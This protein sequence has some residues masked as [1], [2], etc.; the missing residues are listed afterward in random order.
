MTEYRKL[1]RGEAAGVDAVF[2]PLSR[3][4]FAASYPEGPHKLRHNLGA[5]P[6]LE[7]DALAE[8]AEALPSRSVAS[9]S[10]AAPTIGDTIRGIEAG[11]SWAVLRNIERH[12][13][14][15]ALLGEL[16][17]ELEAEIVAKTGRIVKTQGYVFLSGPH[18]VTPFHFRAAHNLLL[19]LAGNTAL[20]VFPAGD[21]L[22]APDRAHEAC[23]TGGARELAW[24]DE[25]ACFGITLR[26][27][28]GEAAFVPVKAPHHVRNC[29]RPS[30]ALSIAWHSEWSRAEADARACNGLLRRWGIEPRPPGRW[31]T[32]NTGKAI[33]WRILRGIPG[34]R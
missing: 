21:P 29:P 3:A 16:L 26:L 24:R 4:N 8:L 6:L 15:A 31:P 7:L 11:D 25:L 19:Q 30:I 9:N 33:A 23:R 17:D 27:A 22:F 10:T 5:H 20:T 28:A 14:Y 32:R 13:A 1:L 18:A 34:I 2:P 12:P